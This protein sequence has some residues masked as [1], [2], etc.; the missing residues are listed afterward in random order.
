MITV[1]ELF[2]GIG[3]LGL[4]LEMTGRFEVVWQV[5]KDDWTTSSHHRNSNCE[6]ERCT[7]TAGDTQ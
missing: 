4:G 1:G 6:M 7:K 2:A 5:E 3:G